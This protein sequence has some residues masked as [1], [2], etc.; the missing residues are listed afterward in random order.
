VTCRDGQIRPAKVRR[1]AN[2]GQQVLHQREVQHLL[3][4]D[5]EDGPPP[6]QD[7]LEFLG[8]K[9]FSLALLEGKG[10]EEV[11]AHDAV[12]KLRRLAQH[13]DQCLAMLDDKRSLR[14]G[15]PA[16]RS[17]ELS[18]PSLPGGHRLL[19]SA[20]MPRLPRPG[21]PSSPPTR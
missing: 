3:A 2:R 14:R 21:L 10:R 16:A 7:R 18:E 12:L 8:G 19:I 11:L 5:A 9:P 15:K 20:H 4:C 1:R 6:P 17:Y 13:V